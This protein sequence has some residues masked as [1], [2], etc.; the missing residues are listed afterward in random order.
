MDAPKVTVEDLEMFEGSE[1]W[2]FTC[3]VHVDG[4]IAAYASDEGEGGMMKVEWSPSR[5]PGKTNWESLIKD[6]LE[7]YCATFP[8]EDYVDIVSLINDAI[9]AKLFKGNNLEL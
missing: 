4:E 6:R 7:T 9:D 2:G 1:G 5:K 8:P 3:T